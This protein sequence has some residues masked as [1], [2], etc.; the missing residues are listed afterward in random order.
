MLKKPKIRL[1]TR[2]AQN[3]EHVLAD[4]YRAATRREPVP[5]GLFQQAASTSLQELAYA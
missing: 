4:V 5:N 2:A 3:H 1:L